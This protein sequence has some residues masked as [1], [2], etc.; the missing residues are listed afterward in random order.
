M[1]GQEW[2]FNLIANNV[3]GKHGSSILWTERWVCAEVGTV[4]II[5]YDY[6]GIGGCF[7]HA[8]I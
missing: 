5:R 6:Y 4:K 1:A 8:T 2:E 3:P 7:S